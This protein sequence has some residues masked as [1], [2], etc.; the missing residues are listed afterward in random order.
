MLQNIRSKMTRPQLIALG[1]FLVIALGTILLMLPVATEPGESTSFV[2]ALFTATSSTCVTGLVVADTSVHWSIFGQLVILVMIQIGGLGFVTIGVL[3]AMFLNKK[4][5]LR[6]RGLVQ[7]SMNTN[8]VGGM[9]RLVRKVIKGTILIELTGAALLSIRFVP[10]FGLAKGLCFGLFHS[11]SAFCNAGFDLMGGSRGEYSSFT[12]FSDDIL[13]NMVIMSL[14]VVG[15]IGFLVWDD[16]TKHR[17]QVKKYMLHTKIVLFT[18]IVLIFGGALFFYIFE[19]QNLMADMPA[20]ETVLTSLFSSVTAR[21]AGFNTIDTAGL[22]TSSKLLTILLMFIGG[23]P[24]STA[25]GI[26]TTTIIVLLI[27]VWSNLRNSRGCNIFG[28]RL[29]DDAIRKAS[30]VII[31]SLIMAITASIAIC[32]L[33]PLPMEDVMFEVFSAIGTVGMSTGITRELG[34]ASRIIIVLLMY[35]GRIGSMAFALSFTERRKVAP[36]QCPV[37]KV[38]IG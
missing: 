19:R 12:T 8:Q 37:E 27:Y 24:G 31:I 23:S 28:R 25:G 29:E 34:T 4:I 6:T 13:V 5:N 38:M 26:K 11:V 32:Y 15:G 36:V 20:G 17:L 18:T 21:T 1:Y 9:V 10:E 14:I 33:Q 2:T 7:E 16:V 22:T 30:N 35:C 3:F